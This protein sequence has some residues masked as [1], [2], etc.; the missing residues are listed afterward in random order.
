LLLWE[1]TEQL[2]VVRDLPGVYYRLYH[3]AVCLSILFHPVWGGE[4]W[5]RAWHINR[6][7]VVVVGVVLL[8]GWICL[9]QLLVV[10]WWIRC[11]LDKLVPVN[12]RVLFWCI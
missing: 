7:W 9:I 6:Y 3:W 11:R 1:E 4:R 8:Y 12:Q 10:P 2:Q 5:D